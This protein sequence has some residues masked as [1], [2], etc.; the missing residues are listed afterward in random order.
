MFLSLG[1]AMKEIVVWP[2]VGPPCI[3]DHVRDAFFFLS[4][5]EEE[6]R[7]SS[8]TDHESPVNGGRAVVNPGP[9]G[10]LWRACSLSISCFCAPI[11]FPEGN[12]KRNGA[13][14][15]LSR[16]AISFPIPF[17]ALMLNDPPMFL[18]NLGQWIVHERGKVSSA[19]QPLTDS[20]ACWRRR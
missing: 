6:G 12:G 1:A 17:P 8:R 10:R 20:Q 7:E 18:A 15:I 19:V 14:K 13:P 4:K 11:T 9:T 3:H 2:T 5:R 16:G